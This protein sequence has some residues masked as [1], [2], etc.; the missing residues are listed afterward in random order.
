MSLWKIRER[1]V[2]RQ[3]KYIKWSIMNDKDELIKLHQAGK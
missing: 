2:N 1:E 3:A